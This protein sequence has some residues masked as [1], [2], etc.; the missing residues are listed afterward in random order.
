MASLVAV[1]LTTLPLSPPA[2]D[3]GGVPESVPDSASSW[4]GC[5]LLNGVLQDAN[6]VK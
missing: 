4:N 2:I 5:G 3:G 6:T 1:S